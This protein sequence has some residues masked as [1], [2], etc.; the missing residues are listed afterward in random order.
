MKTQTLIFYIRFDSQS[1][2]NVSSAFLGYLKIFDI[3]DQTFNSFLL[4][5][6]GITPMGDQLDLIVQ[7]FDPT[8]SAG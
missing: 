6:V 5:F 8:S 2:F 7:S 3:F 4:F 1:Y